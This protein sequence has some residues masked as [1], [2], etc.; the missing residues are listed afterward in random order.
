M[1]TK[2]TLSINDEKIKKAK[3]FSKRRGRSVSK[4]FEDFIDSLEK[5]EKEEDFDINKIIGAFGK[6]PKNFDADEVKWKYL[7]EK[8]GL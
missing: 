7:K 6:A 5:E 1:T 8:H 4:L 3:C 2:L